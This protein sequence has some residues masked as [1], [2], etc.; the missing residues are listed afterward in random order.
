MAPPAQQAPG[1]TLRD[2]S[3]PPLPTIPASLRPIRGPGAPPPP[4][5]MPPPP[6]APGPGGQQYSC[7]AKPPT[8]VPSQQPFARHL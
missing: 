6:V 7:P 3:P 4:P 8:M 5:R 1:P 2:A